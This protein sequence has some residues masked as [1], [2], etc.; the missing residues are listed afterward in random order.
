M[1]LAEP[2]VMS[3]FFAKGGLALDMKQCQLRESASGRFK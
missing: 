2:I 3:G 1:I